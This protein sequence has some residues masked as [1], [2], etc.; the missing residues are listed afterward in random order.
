MK[1]KFSRKLGLSFLILSLVWGSFMGTLLNNTELKA[2][3]ENSNIDISAYPTELNASNNNVTVTVS[4]SSNYYFEVYRMEIYDQSG[5]A[6]ISNNDY[7]KVVNY[8]QVKMHSSSLSAT[9]TFKKSDVITVRATL[10][11]R[12]PDSPDQNPVLKDNKKS[13]SFTINYTSAPTPT[14]VPAT[15]TPVPATPTPKPTQA[16]DKPTP[17]KAPDTPTPTPKP[18]TPTPTT[19]TESTE[20]ESLIGQYVARENV[21]MRSGPSLNSDYIGMIT[22]GEVVDIYHISDNGWYKAYFK[23]QAVYIPGSYLEEYD[24][25]TVKESE[26]ETT[27]TPDTSDSSKTS[28]SST[29]NPSESSSAPSESSSM[30]PSGSASDSMPTNPTQTLPGANDSSS[31]NKGNMTVPLVIIGLVV[32]L[33]IVSI[34][35]YVLKKKQGPGA[36]EDSDSNDNNSQE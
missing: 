6:L 32:V 7:Y 11:T 36:G 13:T 19:Q 2:A 14:P 8:P 23:G 21:D 18:A 25:H 24:S 28:E 35:L 22:A 30:N 5:N 4:Y 10:T 33:A 15:P 17:T 31:K 3:A 1:S 16:P 34:V 29:S 27:S 12:D 26:S 20:N 9:L